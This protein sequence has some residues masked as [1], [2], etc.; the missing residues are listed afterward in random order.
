MVRLPCCSGMQESILYIY[1][2]KI[3]P[4]TW[5]FVSDASWAVRVPIT[6]SSTSAR[7]PESTVAEPVLRCLVPFQWLCSGPSASVLLSLLQEAQAA[8]EAEGGQEAHAAPG[9]RGRAAG[10]LPRT[11]AGGQQ[12]LRWAVPSTALCGRA[13]PGYGRAGTRGCLSGGLWYVIMPARFTRGRSCWVTPAVGRAV[14]GLGG[15]VPAQQW[16]RLLLLVGLLAQCSQPGLVM[17]G[18]A[19][20]RCYRVLTLRSMLHSARAFM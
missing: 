20:C 5:V 19:R 4:S 2:C 15:A 18:Q 8:G 11:H 3:T 14:R 10:S 6:V 13:L 16:R 1:Q 12:G 7:S 17:Q 9:Q